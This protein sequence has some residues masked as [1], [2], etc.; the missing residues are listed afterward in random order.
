MHVNEPI[1]TCAKDTFL[2][3]TDDL[4]ERTDNKIE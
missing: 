1:D 3:L 2:K 4:L